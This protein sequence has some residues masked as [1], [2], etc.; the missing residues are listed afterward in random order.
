MRTCRVSSVEKN[1]LA[2]VELNKLENSLYALFGLCVYY[3]DI[4]NNSCTNVGHSDSSQ[5]KVLYLFSPHG[6]SIGSYKIIP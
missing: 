4:L 1:I 5:T 3:I 6:G 2:N